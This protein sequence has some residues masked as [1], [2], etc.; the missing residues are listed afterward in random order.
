MVIV[1]VI[2]GGRSS[3]LLNMKV[4]DVLKVKKDDLGYH[5]MSEKYKT[6]LVYGAKTLGLPNDMFLLYKAYIEHVRVLLT[7]TS[8]PSHVYLYKRKWRNHD[9][10]INLHRVDNILQEGRCRSSGH[11]TNLAVA[12]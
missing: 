11:A 3:N 4:D 2:N 1:T 9:A 8:S 6:C 7:P 5:F 10:V 12:H